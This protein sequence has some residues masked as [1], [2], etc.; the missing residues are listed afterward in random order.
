MSILTQA[1]DESRKR[2]QQDGGQSV[3]RLAI[4]RARRGETVEPAQG[5]AAGPLPTAG[6][7]PNT[8]LGGS[9]SLPAPSL[10][11]IP[12]LPKAR[13]TQAVKDEM[14]RVDGMIRTLQERR[15]SLNSQS[16][17]LTRGALGMG[18]NRQELTNRAQA[19][20]G[21]V[22]DLDAEI[23]RLERDRAG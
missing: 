5:Q 8:F 16:L 13:G 18:P 15:S 20:Q 14:G 6:A 10:T 9:R 1:I 22:R 7:R 4:D 2:T 23:T 21:Q 11:P 3:L 12:T 19:L 17:D